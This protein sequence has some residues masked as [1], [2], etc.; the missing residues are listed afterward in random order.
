MKCSFLNPNYHVL[1]GTRN[2][3]KLCIFDEVVQLFFFG[4]QICQ[5]CVEVGVL[6]REIVMLAPAPI[7]H[8][9]RG[10]LHQTDPL[11]HI[12]DVVDTTLKHQP[13]QSLCNSSNY[14]G[15]YS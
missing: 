5:V 7:H 13:I 10:L 1:N 14:H 4:R 15:L 11:Q 9:L 2:Y 3:L 12:R 8:V 6:R